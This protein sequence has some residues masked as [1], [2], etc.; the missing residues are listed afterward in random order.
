MSSN[1]ANKTKKKTMD[2][3]KYLRRSQD[4]PH[5]CDQLQTEIEGL[6][7]SIQ[8]S[9]FHRCLPNP[10]MFPHPNIDIDIRE[11]LIPLDEFTNMEL[12]FLEND[13]FVTIDRL[14]EIV[15]RLKALN[16][17]IYGG[18]PVFNFV[19]VEIIQEIV[20]I[21]GIVEVEYDDDDDDDISV[22]C[23]V[24]EM[25]KDEDGNCEIRRV[26]FDDVCDRAMATALFMTIRDKYKNNDLTASE[27]KH[28]VEEMA[29][30]DILQQ[31]DFDY[32]G[33]EDARFYRNIIKKIEEKYKKNKTVH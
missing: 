4:I 10:L 5:V 33:K 32:I 29:K 16:L 30:H 19:P 24:C 25:T 11:E 28:L 2:F 1:K 12:A 18:Y 6:N 14:L 22:G 15:P 31:V 17:E 27:F 3:I 7:I 20:D 26:N 9:M 8:G 13:E 23:I 21:V